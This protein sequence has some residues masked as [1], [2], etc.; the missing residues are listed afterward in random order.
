MEDKDFEEILRKVSAIEHVTSVYICSRAGAFTTG[1]TPKLADRSMYSAITSL[2]YGTAEQVGHEMNDDL[3]YVSLNF[4]QSRLLV[5][6]IGP[7]NL[8]G[9]LI[10]DKGD[11]DDVLKDVQR[12]IFE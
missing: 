8:M 2:A 6:G 4:T 9:L 10:D 1:I 5:V 12:L 11:P 3:Q 7:R